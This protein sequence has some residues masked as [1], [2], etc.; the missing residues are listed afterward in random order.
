MNPFLGERG[1][2]YTSAHPE[3]FR[4]QIRALLRA[5]V[6]G[7]LAIIFPMVSDLAQIQQAT[8]VLDEVKS[9]VGGEAEV[10]IMIEIPAAALTAGQLA[11][12]ITFFSVGT[13]DLVQYGLAVDR[14]NPQV[15]PLYRPLHPGILRL[16]QMTVEGAHAQGRWV[17]VC[18]EMAGDLPA[19]PILVGLGFDELSMTPGRIPAAKARIRSLDATVCRELAARSLLCESADDVERLVRESLPG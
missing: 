9:E 4:R 7:K 14:T 8:Q 19:I 3:V 11:R 17:G 18:G 10:G 2:R 13:N 5:S 16:L 12:H 1:I 6:C 15:A